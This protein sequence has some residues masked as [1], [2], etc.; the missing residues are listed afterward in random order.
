M[1]GLRAGIV[2]LDITPEFHPAYGAWGTTPSMTRI[3][4][5]L[6]A[7]CVALQVES[8][9]LL[10]YGLDLVGENIP[11][12]E[13]IRDE[14]ADGLHLQRE[15]I[16]WSTSQTHSCGALPG[17]TH[18]G[19]SIAEISDHAPEFAQAQR[20]R[21][22]N[23]CIEAGRQAVSQL[24]PCKVWAGR[25]YCDSVSYNRRFPM[26]TGGA[27]FSRD[28]AEG[29]QSGKYFDAAIG[30]IRFEDKDGRPIGGI[31][32]FNAHP[33]TMILNTV[34]SPDWV[35][36]ARQCIEESLGDAPVM[37]CQG[38]CGDVC[39]YHIFG[40]PEK[41]KETGLRLGMAAIRALPTL[42]PVRGTPLR[43]AYKTIDV[44]CQPMPTRSAFERA[45]AERQAFIDRLHGEPTA[46]WVCG[47]NLPEQV[48]AEQRAAFVEVQMKYFHEGIR[49]LDAGESPRTSLA[50]PLGAV[51]IGDV[52]A[53]LSGGENFAMT[54]ANIR[55]RSPFP[56]T[57]IC[58]DT[59]GMFG[60][61][62]DDAEIDRGGYETDTY[63]TL[64]YIDD[65]RLPPA[66]GTVDR[67]INA[68]VEL[69]EQLRA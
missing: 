57:L 45:L 19:C 12:T 37:F 17:S 5:P 34:M 24:Q 16:I 69:L 46:T 10:W 49:M 55:N 36:T 28:Y 51:R 33:A 63:W 40:T 54:G 26:P 27:K 20:K 66:R 44:T 7:R 61:I 1:S 42:V 32:N 53:F 31:L 64:L 39:C 11:N 21:F 29:L 38:F 62:G 8:R 13:S 30:L 52:A 58:G 43:W 48:T 18:T 35:G 50:L 6:L 15:Q 67:I 23:K 2:G 68:A 65:F 4:L 25:G 14:V 60:Y 47:R 41:A 22:M 56:H 9:L 3:D 59:N